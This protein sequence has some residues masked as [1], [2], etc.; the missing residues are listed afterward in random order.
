MSS[1]PQNP[2]SVSSLTLKPPQAIK[3]LRSKKNNSSNQS[4]VKPTKKEYRIWGKIRDGFT[5]DVIAK[6][7]HLD[8]LAVQAAYQKVVAYM[9]VNSIEVMRAEAH[10][11]IRNKFST[12]DRVFD[13]LAT[14]TFTRTKI[15][16]DSEGKEIKT[17]IYEIDHATRRSSMDFLLKLRNLV[18]PKEKTEVQYG[19]RTTN[20][21]L[22]MAGRSFESQ[23]RKKREE[24]GLKN[25][26]DSTEQIP[27]AEYEDLEEDLEEDDTE[28]SEENDNSS[29]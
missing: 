20:N 21:T 10:N 7:E 17:E 27:D 23:I 29:S 9:R 13:E 8:G 26:E 11:L 22:V 4:D 15:E 1:Q 25:D 28:E 14:A 3:P 16:L 24:R 5:D 6:S 2:E 18:A 12:L 19:D